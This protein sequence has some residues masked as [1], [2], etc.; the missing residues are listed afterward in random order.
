MFVYLPRNQVQILDTWDV[1][2]LCATGSH[3]VVVE[4]VFVPEA[5]TWKFA[6]NA[7]RGRRYQ[8]PT[9]RFPFMG[10]FSLPMSAVALGIAQSAIDE[11]E[12]LSHVKTPRLTSGTLHEK[13]LFQV[14]FAQAAALVNSARAWLHAQIGKVW[15]TVL[16]G[17][18][19]SLRERGECQL[20]ATNATRSAAAAVEIA[21]TAGGG[22]ANYRRSP[23][24]RQ[25]RDIHAVSQHIGTAPAQ[26]ETSGRMLLGLPPEVPLI[27]L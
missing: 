1:S 8:D 10:L 18:P 14:Q 19:V 27:L 16:R 11:I 7:R 20:A 13:A 9:Y 15:E 23:L 22:G 25:M 6:L 3:D 4:N 24:Q 12:R 26:Y 5:Y 17:E 2:G 21:Y